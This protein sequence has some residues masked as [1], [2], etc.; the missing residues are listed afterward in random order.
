MLL[1]FCLN[2]CA[3]VF[4]QVGKQLYKKAKVNVKTE[5]VT[6]KIKDN[7]NNILPDISTSKGNH[8]INFGQLIEYD[9]RD[10]FL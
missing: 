5:D 7:Y 8:K 10:V 9:M 2:F 3:E 1:S 6:N 4:A